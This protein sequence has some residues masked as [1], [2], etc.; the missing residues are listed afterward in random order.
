MDE[1]ASKP[2]IGAAEE[3]ADRRL[4]APPRQDARRRGQPGEQR[5]LVAP[6][7]PPG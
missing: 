6:M 1:C 3:R 5:A 4:V 2:P 7:V